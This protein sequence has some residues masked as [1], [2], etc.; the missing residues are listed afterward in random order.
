[1]C[2]DA[3]T[4]LVGAPHR[5]SVDMS[6]T[7]LCV[8]SSSSS[9]SSSPPPTAFPHCC[10]AA[11]GSSGALDSGKGNAKNSISVCFRIVLRSITRVVPHATYHIGGN[12]SCALGPDR[13]TD[14]RGRPMPRRI[15][16]GSRTPTVRAAPG[17]TVA[18]RRGWTCPRWWIIHA[19]RPQPRSRSFRVQSVHHED[20]LLGHRPPP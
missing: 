10:G 7:K 14:G 1:M 5:W 18:T 15:G 8:A 6:T 11:D 16:S 19:V 9:S 2:H 3:L 17:S 13:S 4:W 20:H 12:A